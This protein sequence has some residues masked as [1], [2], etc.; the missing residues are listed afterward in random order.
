MGMN[1]ND[2]LIAQAGALAELALG[3]EEPF[4][5]IGACAR[6]KAAIVSRMLSTGMELSFLPNPVTFCPWASVARNV[7][8][9][10]RIRRARAVRHSWL[11]SIAGRLLRQDSGLRRRLAATLSELSRYELGER[12]ACDESLALF[13]LER[14]RL[15]RPGGL[16]AISLKE[17]GLAMAHAQSPDA[18]VIESPT[19]DLDRKDA[20]H[21]ASLIKSRLKKPVLVFTDK[22]EDIEKICGMFSAIRRDE[23]L[24]RA[25]SVDEALSK[26]PS[27]V[28]YMDS[29]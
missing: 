18:Y 7:K 22:Y 24:P 6:L 15:E 21:F 10:R 25:I 2:E 28:E 16:P 11:A 5:V 29:I 13:E 27:L 3:S 12:G 1:G 19:A 9:A 17:L 26:H 23:P 20:A 14:L 8:F 4:G